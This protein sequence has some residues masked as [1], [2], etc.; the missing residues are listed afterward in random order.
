MFINEVKI[1]P[2][3]RHKLLSD[4]SLKLCQFL[5]LFSVPASS[6]FSISDWQN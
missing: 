6:R 1:T 3:S 4:I 5:T 2:F